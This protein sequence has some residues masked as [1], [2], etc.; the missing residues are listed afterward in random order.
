MSASKRET[1]LARVATALSGVSATVCRS[2]VDALARSEFPVVIIEPVNESADRQNIARIEWTL[3]FKVTIAI[4]HDIPDS[5]SDTLINSVY[6]AIMS[7]N[8]LLDMCTNPDPQSFDWDFQEAD[9]PLGIITMQFAA[10]HQTNYQD[11][12]T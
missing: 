5:N 8:T 9:V 1:I 10:G 6:N 11:L 2:R 4:R 3:N 12:T 7:D